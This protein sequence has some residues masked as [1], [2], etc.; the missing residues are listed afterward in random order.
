MTDSDPPMNLARDD[1]ASVLRLLD[2]A[3]D[4]PEPQREPWLA[5]LDTDLLRL[6]PALRQLLDQR[7]AIETGSFL[8]DLPPLQHAPQGVPGFAVGHR[9]GPY[10][11]L[12]ELGHGGMA[13]VWL[14]ERADAAHGREVALKLPHLGPRA[15][16]IAERFVRERQILSALTHP[17]VASVLDAGADGAQP[18]LAMEYVDG[19]TITDFAARRQLDIRARLRLFLQVLQAVQHAHAQLVIHRDIKPSNVL[20]DTEG[21]VK[22]LDFGVAKLLGDDGAS[23]ETE[24][25]QLGGRAMTP[26]YAS[27]EQVAGQALGTASDVYSLGVLLYELLTG[28]LPYVLKRD[29]PAA[30]E[31]AILAA[32]VD[33]PSVAAGDKSTARALLGD[34][35]TI[36]MKA[37]AVR[38][39][40]RYATAESMAQDVERYLQS[41]PILARPASMRYRVR[42]ALVRHRVGYGVSAALSITLLLGIATTLWQARQAQAQARRAEAVQRFLTTVLQGNDPQRSAGQVLSARDLL[43]QSTARIESDFKDQPEVQ[44]RLHDAVGHIYIEMGEMAPAL[45]QLRLAGAMYRQL[46]HTDTDDFLEILFREC[47]AL[48]EQRDFAQARASIESALRLMQLRHAPPHRWSGRLLAY[49]AWIEAQQGQPTRSSEFGERALQAQRAFSGDNTADYMEIATTLASNHI[50]RGELEPAERLLLHIKTVGPAVPDFSITNQLGNRYSLASLQFN[51]GD[52]AAAEAELRTLLPDI[53]RHLGPLHDRTVLTRALFARTL[54]ERGLFDEAIQQQRSNVANLR[55]RTPIEA[56]AVALGEIQL[57]RVLTMAAR[58]DD[59]VRIGRDTLRYFDAQYA[60]PTRYRENARWYLGEALLGT[61]AL[62]EG[63]QAVEA[64]LRNAAQ[65]GKGNHPLERSGKLLALAVAGRAGVSQ[66]TAGESPRPT[67]DALEA[68]LGARNTRTTRCRAIEAW[69]DAL[70]RR[71]S[72]RAAASR[73]FVDAR[74]RALSGL[75]DAHPLRIELVAA[76]SEIVQPLDATRAGELRAQAEVGYRRIFGRP[77]PAPLLLVH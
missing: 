60:E 38:P 18:W 66:A 4:L 22:L 32:R 34:V 23:H 17:H 14:A 6:R 36:V 64:S 48:V 63:T 5:A 1:W 53:E 40:D 57:V 19:R 2:E 35:D 55:M 61:G 58:Y 42:K 25:T 15:R 76:E 44:A 16:V 11:L 62:D 26:Q 41:L 45:A 43:K 9:I 37:L 75:P 39:A 56:E 46:G 20:V 29:T 24:L 49:Q 71:G 31:E 10:A 74:E 30:L 13:S 67:C 72:D 73:A 69:L 21:Q 47:Q 28:R 51:R 7:R 50:A 3:L 54:A 70:T 65:L 77:M 27:P 33:K 8:K 52:L 59:A 68:A 12:R